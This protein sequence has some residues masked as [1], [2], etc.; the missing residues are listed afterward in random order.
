[1]NAFPAPT[2]RDAVTIWIAEWL[3][4]GAHATEPIPGVTL[5]VSTDGWLTTTTE[6]GTEQ[7]ESV[8][9]LADYAASM[10]DYVTT[11]TAPEPLADWE[12]SLLDNAAEIEEDNRIAYERAAD[13]EIGHDT[14]TAE[15][16]ET[17]ADVLDRAANIARTLAQ[18]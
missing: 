8:Q 16:L 18:R 2:N 15:T 17:L 12:Q 6:H 4:N 9:A 3:L 1:M 7:H 14:E 10:A 11:L 13:A 5:A